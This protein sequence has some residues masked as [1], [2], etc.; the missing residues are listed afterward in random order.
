[1]HAPG[2]CRAEAVSQTNGSFTRKTFRAGCVLV[3]AE[4]GQKG[5]SLQP[6]SLLDRLGFTEFAENILGLLQR[7]I[8]EG[9]YLLFSF[10][11]V[12]GALYVRKG[13]VG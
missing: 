8:S 7:M 12:S 4:T 3:T 9:S 10:Y 2:Q 5:P 1:M 13:P 6:T 11:S